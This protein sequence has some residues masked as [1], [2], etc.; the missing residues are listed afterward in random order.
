[1]LCRHLLDGVTDSDLC[2][3]HQLNP[4]LYYR[5]Q[6]ELFEGGTA[7]FAKESNRQVI[8]LKKQL[9][10]A[11]EQLRSCFKITQVSARQGKY[12]RKSAVYME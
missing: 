12:R 9:S 8:A 5:W 7:A 1:M 2:D 4:N 6:K 11:R 10:A 3:E